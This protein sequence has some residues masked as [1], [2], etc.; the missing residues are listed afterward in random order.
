MSNNREMA[1][2][3]AVFKGEGIMSSTPKTEEKILRTVKKIMRCV[4]KM[5]ETLGSRTPLGELAVKVR[6]PRP[7]SWWERADST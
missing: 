5:Q 7:P 6:C 2:I 1:R 3:V 4:Y